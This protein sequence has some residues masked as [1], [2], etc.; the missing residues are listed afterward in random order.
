MSSHH[1]DPILEMY[2]FEST[3]LVE[4]LET[5]FLDCEKR[6]TFTPEAINEIFRFMH[7]LKGSSAMMGFAGIS[8]LAH[9][10]EDLFACLRD[11]K[12]Q[13]VEFASLFDLILDSLDFIKVEVHKIKNGYSPDGDAAVLADRLSVYLIQ[14][15]GASSLPVKLRE[16]DGVLPSME[17]FL[18]ELPSE[19][20]RVSGCNQLFRVVI[21]F[22]EDCGME[23]VRAYQIVHGLTE[24]TD[25]FKFVPG[26][27]LDNHDSAD[28]IRKHGFQVFLDTDKSYEEVRTY[29]SSTL[30]LKDLDI[31]ATGN[32]TENTPTGELIKEPFD[33][34]GQDKVYAD[35]QG[36][37]SQSS[38]ISVNVA[39]LDKLMD[40]VGELVIAEAMV[41]QNPELKGL[42]LD[43]F[44]KAA[45]Q[46][47][48]ISEELQDLVMSIRMVPVATAF[49]KMR[50]IVRD[51]CKKLGKE[52]DVEIIGEETEMDK[53]VIDQLSD[54]IMHIVRNAVDHGIELPEERL[55]AG[56]SA[57]GKIT[58][59][60]RNLGSE[61][62]I[63]MRDDGRGLNK[64][65]ILAI[66]IERG[67]LQKNESE[68]TDKEIYNLILLPGFST[69][70]NVTEF[71]G[72]GV[73]MDVVFK[74]LRNLGGAIAIDSIPGRGAGMSLRIPLTLAIIDG[75]NIRVGASCYTIPTL[76]IKESFRPL[77]S[78]VITD[79][80]GNEM[81]M[82]RGRCYPILRIHEIYDVETEVTD[83]GEGILIMVEEGDK[84]LCLLADE[85]LGQQQVVVK[86]LPNYFKKYK[87]IEGLSGCTLLGDGSISLIL[88]VAELAGKRSMARIP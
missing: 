34:S 77:G 52:V 39:K 27:I 13:N 85:L 25:K 35:S 32:E 30:Y 12:P 2:I 86:T 82:V 29:F 17:H 15:K 42:D 55:A 87:K 47:S 71:S 38:M 43:N 88:D 49:H 26:D 63:Q 36:T 65:S 22:S 79:P 72:R 56:K 41:T 74:K 46:L 73:G 78:D 21:H 7:T 10:V 67:L 3:Q 66:A 28:Y 80:D 14:L 81:I 1:N 53:N 60:A 44:Q 20:I 62:L 70:E 33:Q 48:K 75:M 57:N 68:M 51:M 6:Q 83:I 84:S 64:S 40:M 31:Y 8:S 50:R 23:N 9:L 69:K 61:V 37:A 58:L 54:P 19:P 24:I 5:I 18:P 76:S 16:H 11:E 45:R 59:E 4:Q